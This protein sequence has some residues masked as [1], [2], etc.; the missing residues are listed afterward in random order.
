M[1]GLFETI[2]AVPAITVLCLLA[3]QIVKLFT[4]WD[5]RHLPVFCG[6]IGL[7]LGIMCFVW[8]PDFIHA[9]NI[10]AA[11]ATGIVSGWAATGINQV[12]KQYA[13]E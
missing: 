4:P 12:V 7:L 13:N 6:V 8:F 3:A 2:T 5:N 10:V 11:A 1:A 9:Q